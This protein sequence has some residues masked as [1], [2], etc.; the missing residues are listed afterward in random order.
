MCVREC[1]I[2]IVCVSVFVFWVFACVCLVVSTCNTINHHSYH[3]H[4][5]FLRSKAPLFRLNFR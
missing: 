3:N 4:P 2:I 5:K 1:N